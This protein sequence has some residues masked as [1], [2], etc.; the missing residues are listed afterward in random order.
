[1][2][3]K[4]L[5]T[6]GFNYSYKY[7]SNSKAKGNPIFII[8]G[9]FQ[10]MRSWSHLVSLLKDRHAIILADLPGWGQSDLLPSMYD[11]DI[12]NQFIFEILE[13]EHID[14]IN[15]LS[16]SFGTLIGTAFAKCYPKHVE[17]L[18]M[19]SPITGIKQSLQLSYPKMKDI[20]KSRDAKKL[21]EFLCNIGLV[22]CKAGQKGLIESFD[23][24]FKKFVINIS[25]LD[26]N[27]LGKFMANTNRILKFPDHNL[28]GIS[29]LKTLI[30]SGVYDEFTAPDDCKTIAKKI[31]DC[32]LHFVPRSD[33]MFL[34][35]QPFFSIKKIERFL[36]K[37]L[38]KSGQYQNQLNIA[39]SKS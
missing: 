6:F 13:A 25:R 10:S 18:V 30:L 28:S 7:I 34:Y 35:E 5:R 36:F 17:R 21:S 27:H 38:Q 8:N 23:I 33:H 11:F 19:C 15:I 22:N 24:L 20:I 31:Q 32:E 39:Y 12:Y 2:E 1:M 3:T 37:G 4:T 14:K 16:S 26:A 29:N 9:A